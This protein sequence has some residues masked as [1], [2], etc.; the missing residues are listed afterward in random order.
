MSAFTKVLKETVD[1]KKR[2]YRRITISQLENELIA[3]L[4]NAR[5][6]P[7]CP[8]YTTLFPGTYGRQVVLAPL[9]KVS[10]ETPPR[11]TKFPGKLFTISLDLKG[12][13]PDEAILE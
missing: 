12:D 4:Q 6:D 11:K 13:A 10:K 8:V 2:K 5:G 3:E 9:P 7:S 1:H